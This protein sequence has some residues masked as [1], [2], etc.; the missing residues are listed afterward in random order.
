MTNEEIKYLMNHG[1]SVSEVMEMESPVTNLTEE[2]PTTAESEKAMP[3]AEVEKEEKKTEV[4]ETSS[5]EILNH[6]KSLEETIKSLQDSNRENVTIQAPT[7][8]TDEQAIKDFF[9]K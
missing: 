1:F 7:E 2:K 9:E 3:L 4:L 8:Y 5:N 6:I